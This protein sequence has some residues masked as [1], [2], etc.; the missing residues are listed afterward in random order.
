MDNTHRKFGEV[1]TSVSCGM[2]A[3]TDRQTDKHAHRTSPHP[4]GGK[5]KKLEYLAVYGRASYG[6]FP[7]ALNTWLKV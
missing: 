1:C 5:L 2:L 7:S 3:Y 6:S 4:Y